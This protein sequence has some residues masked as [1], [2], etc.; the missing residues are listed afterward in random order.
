MHDSNNTPQK[1]EL[2][3]HVCNYMLSSGTSGAAIAR[4]HAGK[5]IA[6]SVRGL[7]M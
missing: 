4:H 7:S 1:G 2:A 5:Q 3:R 6:D